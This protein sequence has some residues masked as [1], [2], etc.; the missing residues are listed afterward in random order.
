MDAEI[1]EEALRRGG[2]GCELSAWLADVCSR[3]DLANAGRA[4]AWPR[5]AELNDGPEVSMKEEPLLHK[6]QYTGDAAETHH[7]L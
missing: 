2:E 3:T 1:L 6:R 5:L 7:N 4:A